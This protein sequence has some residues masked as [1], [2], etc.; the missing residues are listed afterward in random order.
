MTSEVKSFIELSDILRFR[1][2][3]TEC[4]ASLELELEDVKSGRLMQCPSCRINWAVLN[5]GPGA[6]VSH[7]ATFVNLAKAIREIDKSF[8]KAPFGFR[9]K[10]QIKNP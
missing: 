4:K 2:E 5:A 3:C 1:F 6:Q 8:E 9:L 10:L 7:E